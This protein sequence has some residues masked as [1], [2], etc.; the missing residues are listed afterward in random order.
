MSS[1]THAELLGLPDPE[2]GRSG[3]LA[4][5][6]PIRKPGRVLRR[7]RELA[8]QSL[9]HAAELSRISAPRLEAI[10]RD[11]V[12]P[13]ADE[14]IRLATHFGDDPQDLLAT[15]QITEPARKTFAVG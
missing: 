13:T 11:E 7:L 14:L 15:F 5:A 8:D 1:L 9:Q 12:K 10:E 2:V 3:T 4:S 6:L